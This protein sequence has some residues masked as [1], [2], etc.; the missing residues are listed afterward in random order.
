MRCRTELPADAKFCLECGQ[1]VR[2]PQ[3]VQPR[4]TSPEAYTP[5]HLAEKILASRDK[6]EGERKQVTVL[7]ADMKGYTPLAEALGEEAVYQLM[8]RIY[9]R[10]LTAVHQYGGTVQEL[11]G[12]GILALFG[13]PVALEDAPLRACRAALEIQAQMT[14][15]GEEV[16]GERGVKPQVRIGIHTGPVVVGTV[17]TDLRMEFKAVGDTVNLASRLESMAEPG[18]ILISEATHRF[19]EDYVRSAF[20]GEREVKGKAEPQRVY[21]VETLK[22][23]AVR[24]DASLRRGLTPLVGRR[25]ELE[26]LERCYHEARGGAPRVVNVVGEAGIG[27]SRLV[28]E[29][30]QRLEG[31]RIVFLEGHCTAYGRTTSFL[32]FIEVVRTVFRLGEG[33]GQQ[34]VERKVRRGLELLGLKA[35]ARLP[36]LLNLLGLDPGREAFQGLD[37]EIVGARTREVLQELLR[38]RCRLSP[39]VLVMEDLHWIDT[40]SEELL[41]RAAQS[42]E[43]IPL[44]ILCAYRPH[45]RAPWTGRENVAELFLEPLSEDSSLHLVQHRLGTEALPEEL[46]RV[47]VDKAE[48]N[49]LFAEELTRYLQESGSLLRTDQGVSFRSGRG[50]VL[51]PGTLQ[52][53][54]MARVDRLAEGPRTV[55]QVASVIGRR[56][57]RELVHAVSGV[58][59]HMPQ[60]L[61]DLEAQELIFRHEAEGREEY[62][63]KHA[64][65]QDAIYESLL[66]PRR[67]GLHQRV[68]EAIEQSYPDRLGEWADVLAHHWS[69]TTSA[70]KAVRYLAL[71][72]KKSLRVYSLD[73]AH[74]RFSQVVELMQ[75]PGSADEGYL[76]D[77]LLGWALVHYYRKDFKGLIPLVERHLPRVEA[78]RDTRR[79]SL[80]LFWLGFSRFG[81]CRVDTGRALLEKALALGEELADEECIGY[82]SMGLM[83]CYHVQRGQEYPDIVDRLGNRGLDI[84]RSLGDVYLASKCLLCFAFDKGFS[85]R[86]N[87]ARAFSLR[88]LELGRGAR[89]P[90]TIAA[91]LWRL[92]S[93]N[94]FDERYEEAIEQAEEALRISPDPLDR[95]SARAVKGLAL[96]MM[97]R[98]Q[99]G[100]EIIQEVRRE[101]V[102]GEFLYPLLT[103]D[104][105][106]GA[107]MVLAGRMAAGVRWVEDAIRRFAEW[108]N[109]TQPTVGHMVLGEIYLQMALGEKKPPLRIILKN[110]GFV[111]RTLP[112]AARKARRHL[113]E[114]IRLTR[115]L[116]MPG[117]L[118]RSLLDLGLLCKA[119]KR[120]A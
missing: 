55:L 72:G 101:F 114:A 98:G 59:G 37:G 66:K 79:L 104:I 90:R 75:V 39:V 32:P 54:I 92:G 91:G 7:F 81:A 14:R 23:G 65:V 56:F 18:T 102:A 105:P 96:T 24:F 6:I 50:G 57:P 17:G 35:E 13:A 73:E 58:N 82:A 115:E 78:L 70:D 36:F 89:D 3:L 34:E 106:Y 111:L 118:A 49:P 21:R 84:A 9:E 5:K 45:Y 42:T 40:A 29:L 67:D 4:F 31:D 71:A 53:I 117:Y 99:E 85:G 25:R 74:E 20:L 94:A 43:R 80:L 93:V 87:E 33:E 52:D 108:G 28:H 2:I 88:L 64:L 48:G 103:I 51:V 109:E 62:L 19:V 107:S 63:F 38:E 69:R 47:I 60:Y 110:L 46:T 113:E 41:L 10:M 120:P 44:L 30:R 76:A 26:A 119:K 100:L 22:P 97:G 83:W 8:D 61:H 1:P 15:L 86:F 11:T 16:Q 27:K 68:A 12:D 112:V 116:D 77:A 95:L